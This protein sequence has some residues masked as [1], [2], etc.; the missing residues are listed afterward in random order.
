MS[1]MDIPRPV[2]QYVVADA[3]QKAAKQ[4]SEEFFKELLSEPKHGQKAK[5]NMTQ[6]SDIGQVLSMTI[7]SSWK[8]GEPATLPAN[9]FFKEYH[10][11]NEPDVK[12]CFFYRGQRSSPAAAEAF[13]S[14]LQK[15]DH[16]L[17]PAEIK[18]VAEIM[19]N[20]DD[21]KEFAMLSA[22]TREIN[23]KR[24]LE[25]EGRYTEKQ[26]DAQAIYV[27]AE[28]TGS[29]VQEIFYQAPKNQYML[30]QR[31]TRQAFDSIAWK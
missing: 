1:P 3:H 20:K 5:A 15:P 24:V 6:I 26:I 18:S 29:V 30:H 25:V 14:L 22:R 12:L 13:R 16:L 10:V 19:R 11:A 9:A 7:P 4:T 28:G 23:G 31:E 27:D 8:E 17:T 21:A 2:E